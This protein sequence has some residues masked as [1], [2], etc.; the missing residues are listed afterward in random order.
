MKVS[1]TTISN[2]S[3][4][5]SP[6]RSPAKTLRLSKQQTRLSP[7]KLGV[8]KYQVDLEAFKDEDDK[9]THRQGHYLLQHLERSLNLKVDKDLEQLL[10]NH[11]T[12]ESLFSKINELMKSKLPKKPWQQFA[13][14]LADMLECLRDKDTEELL[15]F[16]INV[17]VARIMFIKG[18]N[19]E[20]LIRGN[21]KAITMFRLSASSSYDEQSVW[22]RQ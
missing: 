6:L 7:G 21:N 11:M 18:L 15:G 5:L 1:T 3:D 2:P 12:A 10:G 8:D 16:Q 4:L 19:D 14:P 13:Y 9:L 22:W 20:C 17:R